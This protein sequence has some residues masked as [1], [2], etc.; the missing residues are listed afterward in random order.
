MSARLEC[1]QRDDGN[2]PCTRNVSD[3]SYL[4]TT[5]LSIPG[6]LCCI[7]LSHWNSRLCLGYDSSSFSDK[8]PWGNDLTSSK[9]SSPEPTQAVT[10]GD[11]GRARTGSILKII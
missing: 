9:M 5:P 4:F 11:Y 1:T 10:F 7:R 6:L 3:D 2:G 8:V